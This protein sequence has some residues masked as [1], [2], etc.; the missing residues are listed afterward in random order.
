MHILLQ[1]QFVLSFTYL[2]SLFQALGHVVW[3]LS[4]WLLRL[5]FFSSLLLAVVGGR[6]CVGKIVLI[7]VA[8]KQLVV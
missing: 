3:S 1:G 5:D 4:Q 8:V 2:V 6:C 7:C